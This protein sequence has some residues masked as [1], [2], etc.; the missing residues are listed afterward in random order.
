MGVDRFKLG[1]TERFSLNEEDEK[2]LENP[3][4]DIIIRSNK[5]KNFFASRYNNNL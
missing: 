2:K 1:G 4:R 5:N 3:D